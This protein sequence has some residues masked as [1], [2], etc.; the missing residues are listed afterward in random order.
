M[1]KCKGGL[2]IRPRGV[3][4]ADPYKPK[5]RSVG[6]AVVRTGAFPQ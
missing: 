1:E 5:R 6:S 3:K 2:H 4:D